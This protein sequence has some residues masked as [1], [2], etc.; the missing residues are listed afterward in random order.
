MS[1]VS[2]L[3]MSQQALAVTQAAISVVS[4][5]ISNVDN[6]NY[7]RLT[8]NLSDVVSYSSPHGAI[9]QANSLN[10][11]KLDSITRASSSYLQNY[12]WNENT[13]YS[14]YNEYASLASNVEDIVNELQD[15]GI[16]DALS[17]FYTA[18]SS[19]NN[20]PKSSS[21]R[22]AVV[23]A[24]ENVCSV[25][26]N[27]YNS[28]NSI[29]TSLVGDYTQ[30]GSVNNSEI[31]TEI[32]S[33]N[34][35][36]GQ[37]AQV[38]KGIAN[39]SSSGLD[40]NSLLDERDSIITKLSGY[41]NIDVEISANETAKVSLG[42]TKL[43]SGSAVTGYLTAIT[44]TADE[45]AQINIVKDLTANPTDPSNV[46]L[47]DANS[48][49]TGGT[50]GAI[51]D[52]CGADSSNLTI[53]SI[54]GNLDTMA[55]NFA[56]ILNQ[57]QI[58]DPSG[59]AS[60]AL[61]IDKTTG[62]LTKSNTL[63]FLN[64]DSTAVTTAYSTS[65]TG[66][67]GTTTTTTTG[68]GGAKYTN[69]ITTEY[70]SGTG[71]YNITTVTQ[72]AITASNISVNSAVVSDSDLIAAARV[73]S[74]VYTAGTYTSDTGNNSNSTLMYNTQTNKYSSLDNQTLSGYLSTVVSGVGY[75]ISDINSSLTTQT[76][77]LKEVKSSLADKKGVNLDEELSNLI[78]YQRAYESAARVF[79][80]CSNLLEELMSLGK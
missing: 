47:S 71:L 49:I 13:S 78:I 15:S 42:G 33:V 72:R 20:D 26:N 50:I 44:G 32:D 48:Y 31:G 23:S 38:N 63:L 21:A 75:S 74:T 65:A 14:Y 24:A 76:S 28:L 4:N 2:S 55:S 54:I 45:P 53:S 22:S 70:N 9:A 68:T 29:K 12:Y 64:G 52:L 67:V 40:S 69:T 5:N 19:L 10:G 46:I 43:V 51:L 11:V 17:N 35:L 39:A 6:E 36:L 34:G 57:V 58:G 56:S 25:F 3:N 73:S 30:N 77:V 66:T 60:T 1:L 27:Y 18:L 62:Q 61:C 41:L 37:L 7:S 59:D 16:S 79:T 8:V 80:T